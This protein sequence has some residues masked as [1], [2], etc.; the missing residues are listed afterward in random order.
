MGNNFIFV[1][2]LIKI[3]FLSFLICLLLFVSA[4]AE[5]R[6]LKIHFIDVGEG[7]SILIEAPNG[8][9]ALVDAGNLISGFWVAEY[10]KENG[11]QDLE[12]L[13]FTHPHLDH[14]GGTFFILQMINVKKIYDNGQDLS[15][16]MESFDAYRWYE[17]LV[18]ENDNYQVLKS[19]DKFLVDGVKFRII[20][21][22]YPFIFSDFNANSLVIMVEYKKFRC[23]LSGDLTELGENE[24]LK[25]GIDI[26]ADILKVGHHGS[27]D[28]S[29]KGFLKAISPDISIISVNKDNIRGYPSKEISGRLKDLG[30]KIYRTDLNGNI[31]VIVEDSGRY[32][33]ETE[34]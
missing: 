8:E 14:I 15:Q 10:L 32:S 2:K 33:I 26:K 16:L 3:C 31:I 19:G 29:S 22:P 20:W 17:E 6:P 27:R 1:R 34:R 11:I 24:L 30:A 5:T 13:I 28:A 18:R 23:L 7:D 9:A 4:F 21:P 12:Y 25:S